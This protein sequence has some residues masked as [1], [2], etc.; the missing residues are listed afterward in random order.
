MKLFICLFTLFLVSTPP[1]HS[2]QTVVVEG[3]VREAESGRAVAGAHIWLDEPGTGTVTGAGGEFSVV[4]DRERVVL[5]VSHIG[6]RSERRTLET[7]ALHESL[8][9]ELVPVR[10]PMEGEVVVT[11]A[12]LPSWYTGLYADVRTRPVEEQLRTMAGLDL[13]S[14]AN[15][16]R[17]PVIRGVRDS[18][19][20][21]TID[22]MRMTP[23]CV[24]GMDPLTAYLEADN[25][26]SI[27]INRGQG[28]GSG[29]SASGGSI[30]F[31]TA[32]PEPDSG[33]NASLESGFHS[34]ET[35]QY[36]Q[37]STS[38][39][40]DRWGVRVSGTYRNAGDMHA[41]GG[42]RIDGSSFEKG[43]LHLSGEY[44]PGGGHHVS[45]RYIGDLSGRI[46]Y[47]ALIMDTRR[48]EAHL[49][50]V[51]HQWER[52]LPSLS[53]L[54]TTLYAGRVEHRM[55]DFD[56][57][58]T[59]RDVMPQMHMPMYGETM[60]YGI[61]SEADIITGSHLF[62]V[63]VESWRVE[64]FGDMQMIPLDPAVT[65]MSLLNLGDVSDH[66][67]LGG[68]THTWFA[69]D[70]WRISL[71]GR[72]EAGSS[73]L[74]D[75]GSR[76]IYLAEIPGLEEL[77][78]LRLSWMAGLGVERDLSEIWT[79]GVR[80]SQGTRLPDHMERYGYYIYQPLDGYFYI[81]NPGLKTEMS[82]QAELYALFGRGGS[83]VS[84]TVAAWA[85]RMD[86]YI[87]GRRT[88]A[89]FKRM[90]NMGTALLTGFES[91][92]DFRLSPGWSAAATLSW[93]VGHHEELDEPLP[94]IP[95]LRGTLSTVRRFDR[96]ETEVRLRWAASQNRVADMNHLE[97]RTPGYA[98]L[99]LTGRMRIGSMLRLQAGVENLFDI[100][101]LD[102]L[103]V[104]RFPEPGRNLRISLRFRIP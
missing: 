16:A 38:W 35:Q 23:A 44:R 72:V 2:R 29:G 102:H 81:G 89:L 55:D 63:V 67:F 59:F 51:E 49:F 62:E 34:A 13:V 14:R 3:S 86:R 87:A 32:R 33:W 97:Q 90:E 37:G 66:R 26:Q 79:A 20:E 76:A 1:A 80:F 104:N 91:E 15:M 83:A 101:Y 4:T 53:G 95:P 22:G 58:V 36:Y 61:R 47:P 52:P 9:I 57:D 71:D 28:S 65:E 45:A 60:T 5:T 103:S 18:R 21:V 98:V 12:R 56:R 6:Y 25:M 70:G 17:E 92:L 88:D 42:E 39:S 27:E 40:D 77:D 100:R 8:I 46:G 19:V 48:A 7:G 69:G 94:M 84:G 31:R 10:L 96:F 11:S 99:D 30:H 24:D 43:N 82:R 54:V 78:P 75:P 73:R 41:G 93:I 74:G 50:G 64:A 68:V 85:N